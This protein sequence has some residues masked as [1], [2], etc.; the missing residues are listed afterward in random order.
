MT[1][2]QE[3]LFHPHIHFLVPGGGLAPGQS[4]WKCSRDSFF[5]SVKI[6]SLVFRGKLLS[7]IEKSRKD[8]EIDRRQN[9]K[10]LLVACAKKDW[11]VYSK[12]PFAGPKQVIR[13]LGKYTH[14]IAISNYRLIRL[15]DGFVYFRCRARKKNAGK[16][17]KGRVVK[18]PATEFLGR[19]L[20]HVVPPGYTRIRH[21]GI[22]GSRNKTEKLAKVRE[23]L[24][25]EQSESNPE[26]RGWKEALQDISGIDVTR[27]PQ[28]KKGVMQTIRELP[29]GCDSS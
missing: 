16:K 12:K 26:N 24:G 5:L 25:V 1:W 10:S 18:L 7:L 21:F 14:R 9:L 19:F 4:E 2:T 6:L 11:V 8:L 17:A 23:L 13:Y 15:E 27:C 22:L 20:Q 28:C 3:L 29:E